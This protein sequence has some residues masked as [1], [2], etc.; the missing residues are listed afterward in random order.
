VN[1]FTSPLNRTPEDW[2]YME[3]DPG[4]KLRWNDLGGGS[5]ELQ[6]LATEELPLAIENLSDVRGYA[7]QDIFAPHPTREG[8]WIVKGRLDDVLA[9]SNGEKVVPSLAENIIATH[10][11]VNGV[12][13][14]GRERTQVGAL[15]EP[16]RTLDSTNPATLAEF[17]DAIWPAVLEANSKLPSFGRI[18]RAMILI[19]DPNRP[20]ARSPTKGA[21]VR[22]LA[23]AQYEKEID[24]L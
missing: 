18:V 14:F 6:L 21:V 19:T 16:K 11:L 4:T 2:A 17:R 15:V 22:K 12:V 1:V 9:L 23:Y 13:I 8:F 5:F 24:Q 20:L 7:T 10:P 3:F